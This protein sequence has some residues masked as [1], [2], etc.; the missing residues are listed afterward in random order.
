MTKDLQQFIRLFQE[1]LWDYYR[2][3]MLMELFPLCKLI[4]EESLANLVTSVLFKDASVN[5]VV[6]RCYEQVC[7]AEEEKLMKLID[8][9]DHL[10]PSDM[11][12]NEEYCL[13][14]KTIDWYMEQL[15]AE[16]MVEN[17]AVSAI[18]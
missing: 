1:L 2:V 5:R 8:G 12:V 10:T 7:K 17:M 14:K 16:S 13:N 11:K 15:S 18:M 4:N 6:L 3:E 9:N